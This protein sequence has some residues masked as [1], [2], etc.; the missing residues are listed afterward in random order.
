MNDYR[1]VKFSMSPASEDAADL[2]AAFLADVGFES[3]C[4]DAEGLTAWVRDTDFD[5]AVIDA[6]ISDFPIDVAISY[7]DTFVE[8]RDWN[9]EWELNYFKP[10]VVGN[11]CV[12]HSTF[13]T[14]V[15]K[16]E[17]DIVIDPKMA[18]GTGHHA[19]TSSVI[20]ALLATDLARRQIIDMGTGTAILAILCVMLG[21]EHVT[22]IEIDP[23]A[24][25]N[26]LEN[27]TLNGV[28]EHI[29]LINGDAS[30]LTSLEPADVFVANI[31]RNVITDDMASYAA[32]LKPGGRMILSGFYEQDI[33]VVVEAAKPFGLKELSHTTRDKW[34]CLILTK[35]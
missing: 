10:I 1:E 11:R 25:A 12:I 32:A 33:A 20:E 34:A 22:G 2:M 7:T 3:F 31:N 30:A 26:A 8:G 24:Y 17:Y 15:P 23:A 19:T 16:A 13:H 18:F 14:D 35:S 4:S 5:S 6:I 28:G 29:R 9:R 27:V 21:A